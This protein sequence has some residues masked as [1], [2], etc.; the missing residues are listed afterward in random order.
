M[1]LHERVATAIYDSIDELAGTFPLGGL[2]ERE[3]QAVLCGP[4]SALDSLAIVSLAIGIDKNVEHT[5]GA[6]IPVMEIIF[7]ELRDWTIGDLAARIGDE[8]SSV[9]AE[10]GA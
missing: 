7:E 3:P 1:Q 10:S 5:F 9:G 2:L 6:S 8:L 4:G